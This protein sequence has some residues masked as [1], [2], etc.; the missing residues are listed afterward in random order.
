MNILTVKENAEILKLKEEDIRKLIEDE[1]LPAFK[2]HNEYRISENVLNEFIKKTMIN[3][4]FIVYEPSYYLLNGGIIDDLKV[5]NKIE[6]IDFVSHFAV[7]HNT[8]YEHDLEEFK[9]LLIE[10]E[11]MSST[12]IGKGIALMHTKNIYKKIR[13]PFISLI[14]LK[15]PI[16][17]SSDDGLK[18]DIVFLIGM[19]DE[20]THL[21]ILSMLTK[22]FYKN[23]DFIQKLRTEKRENLL[24][25]IIQE[26]EKILN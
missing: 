1:E 25:L 9:Q 26:E 23:N 18:V 6:L 4:D 7:I 22:I 21:K 5:K 3:K 14:R 15:N 12:G 20:K 16:D 19:K 8:I 11:E 24:D 17:F 10:R 2:I 13:K